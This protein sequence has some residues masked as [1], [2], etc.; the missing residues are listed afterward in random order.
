MKVPKTLKLPKDRGIEEAVSYAV[1]H[2]VRIEVLAALN[3]RAYSA[4]ELSRVVHQP[5]STVTHHIEE[6]LKS[7]SIEIAKTERVRNLSQ[8]FYRAVELPFFSDDE[9]AAMAPQARQEI[10]GVILQA[11]MAEALA[12]F[13]AGKITADP[14]TMLAWRWFNVDE[15]GR[16]DIADEQARSWERIT[17]I[18][19][20]STDRRADSGEQAQSVIVTSLGYERS[21]TSPNPP[22]TSGK[23]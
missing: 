8:N 5:L 1:G 17:E 13:W 22:A 11:V 21:R 12:S 7:G 20:E 10:Y 2:R 23:R 4:Q 19:A 15:Q 9:M 3:E 18:E 6:L 14:R 16:R